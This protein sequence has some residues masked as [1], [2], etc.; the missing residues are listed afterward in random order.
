MKPVEYKNKS[1]K[2]HYYSDREKKEKKKEKVDIDYALLYK[3][4]YR[5]RK[6]YL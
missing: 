2:V 6:R 5:D 4:M 1:Y 3:E